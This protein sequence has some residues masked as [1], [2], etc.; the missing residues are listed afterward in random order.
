MKNTYMRILDQMTSKSKRQR[1]SRTH[2]GGSHKNRRGAG[3]RGGR[4]NAGR[5]KHEFHN[6][7]PLGKNGFS[8]P[9]SVQQEKRE[10]NI[11]ELDEDAALYVS[12]GTALE[13]NESY[14]ID[15]RPIVEDG[16]EVDAVKL[17]G[18]GQ[19]RQQH[20]IVADE[21]SEAARKKVEDNGG[22]VVTL[23]D[24]EMPAEMVEASD[25]HQDSLRAIDQRMSTEWK[26]VR[27]GAVLEFDDIEE[28]LQ[29]GEE[30]ELPELAYRIIL[31]GFK[32]TQEIYPI[33]VPA[34]YL[35]KS[36]AIKHNIETKDID[37]YLDEFFEQVEIPEE[38]KGE[39]RN[40][41]P[42]EVAPAQLYDVLI[43]R[44]E[45][46]ARAESQAYDIDDEEKIAQS[47]RESQR[48]YL[49]VVRNKVSVP[50]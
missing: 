12:E 10:I 34:L 26:R 50:T 42:E 23:E 5:S 47:I 31:R 16:W 37:L 17:I 6:H 39:L 24:G 48:R 14:W 3:H 32:N 36:Y 33:D 40:S 44:G 4:G 15:L 18:N 27:E 41:L 19:V 45:R 9:A 25:I 22:I 11:Q 29:L 21:C 38:F 30:G 46:I 2:G 28:L 49:N 13:L 8:R 20:H 43:D 1:G 35:L 7:P